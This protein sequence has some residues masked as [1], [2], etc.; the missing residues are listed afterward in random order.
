MMRNAVLCSMFVLV[1]CTQEVV[2]TRTDDGAVHRVITSPA[3]AS[4]DVEIRYVGGLK[5]EDANAL[6]SKIEVAPT[7][8]LFPDVD[9]S[10][11]PAQDAVDD[12]PL[13]ETEPTFSVTLHP[14]NDAA[15]AERHSWRLPVERKGELGQTSQA[16]SLN[17][18]AN[19]WLDPGES[20]RTAR[21]RCYAPFTFG[22][23]V[24]GVAKVCID[25]GY[26]GVAGSICSYAYDPSAPVVVVHPGPD[27]NPFNKHYFRGRVTGAT[28]F[29]QGTGAYLALAGYAC[30]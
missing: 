14:I 1:G 8:E 7:R 19:Q 6:A 25:L 24:A 2:S 27:L 23:S 21:Q 15:R 29:G 11:A 17:L 26:D 12:E 30:L 10:K 28:L 22:A 3:G 20:W 13:D 18:A 4:F 16:L 5:R 9:L